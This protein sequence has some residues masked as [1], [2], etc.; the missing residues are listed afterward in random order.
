[1]PKGGL[2]K[3]WIAH[4]SDLNRDVALKEIKATAMLEPRIGAAVPPGSS[5]HRPARTPQHRPRVRAGSPQGRRPAV[6]YH[7]FRAGADSARRNRRIPSAPANKPA[8]RLELQRQLL[9]PFVK[10]C[11]AVGYA[12]SR[13]VIHRDL[14]PENVVLGGHGEVVVLD[15]GLAKVVG[16]ADEEA[17]EAQVT[18]VE[19]SPEAETKSAMGQVGTPAYMAPEQVEARG[20]LI[21]TRTD[22][23]GLGAIL[24][25]IVTRHP[26][27]SG[28]SIGEVFGKIRS[29]NLPKAR[30]VEPTVPRPLEAICAKALAHE[31]QNRY[32]GAED[33][34]EDVRRWLVDEPVSVYRDPLSVRLVRWGRRHRTLVSSSAA[35]FLTAF[36]GLSLG[37]YFVERERERTDQQRKIAENRGIELAQQRDQALANLRLARGAVDNF[38][39][40]VSLDP[41]LR[42]HDLENLRHEL[43]RSAVAAYES[44]ARQRGDDPEILSERGK[45]LGRL[46]EITAATGTWAEALD[47]YRQSVAVLEHLT[48]RYPSVPEYQRSLGVTLNNLGTAYSRGREV[49]LAEQNLGRARYIRETLAVSDPKNLAFQSDLASTH[50][51][52]GNLYR[53]AGRLSAAE[54][55]FE[56]ALAL[57]QNVATADRNDDEVLKGVADTHGNMAGLY[58]HTS[59]RQLAEEA[60]GKALDAR[61][62]LVA[63][64]PSDSTHLRNLAS[65][66]SNLSGFYEDAGQP[67]K[68]LDAFGEAMRIQEDLVARHPTISAYQNELSKTYN[69]LGIFHAAN[70]EAGPAEAQLLKALEIRKRL[71]KSYPDVAEYEVDLADTY[72]NLGHL[73]SLTSRLKDAES[74]IL[75]AQKIRRELVRIHPDIPEYQNNLATGCDNLAVLYSQTG[76]NEDAKATLLE[77]MAIRDGLVQR[78]PNVIDY[79]VGWSKAKNNLGTFYDSIG[80]HD[81]A[82]AAFTD[83]VDKRR[84]LT[85]Q[86]PGLPELRALLAGGLDNLGT[87]YYSTGDFQQAESFYKQALDVRKGLV[88]EF[89]RKPTYRGALAQ[90]HNNLALAYVRLKRM[91]DAEAAFGETISLLESLIREQPKV[92]S[93]RRLMGSSCNNLGSLFLNSGRKRKAAAVLRKGV[94]ITE[95]LVKDNPTD[96]ASRV[97]LGIL[98]DNIGNCLRDSLDQP[99]EALKSYDRALSQLEA[100]VKQVP[101]HAE[102]VRELIKNHSERA[103]T[104]CLLERYADSLPD[105]DRAIAL[106]DASKKSSLEPDRRDAAGMAAANRDPVLAGRVSFEQAREYSRRARDAFKEERDEPA[107]DGQSPAVRYVGHAL[108]RL[109]KSNTYGHLKQPGVINT[110]AE[111]ADFEPLRSHS[112]F[113]KILAEHTTRAP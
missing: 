24:F 101:N 58:E 17:R 62:R 79:Q 51:N 1:M 48:A 22:V 71:V 61:K 65:S 9:E 98:H 89:P 2:G 95:A 32:S 6:L 23:Y 28:K 83:A 88:L 66:F 100:V 76:R 27:A 46:A 37:F 75:E 19:V 10:V 7:A 105:W 110:L 31:R 107:T 73:Y 45:V 12:H 86:N 59:R 13:G 90:N 52:L 60:H 68:A 35:L 8:E 104:L 97:S 41:R 38:Y 93:F 112:E 77:S 50:G 40:R 5:D 15:W 82:L 49:D 30:E 47:W 72:N 3:I 91:S 103:H 102:A 26:P 33:L 44:F 87:A 108:E 109:A 81:L 85:Q 18:G 34:A 21:D 14:K 99:D 54:G 4:D 43:L 92:A 55:A 78:L 11:Q 111:D 106:A 113:K 16:R 57:F 63:R 64:H 29:G 74:R 42:D 20:D 70:R 80:R 53:A 69:N 67:M 96:V 36:L 39:T 84:K 94:E 25:E 56:M